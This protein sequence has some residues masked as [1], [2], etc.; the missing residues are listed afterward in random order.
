[1]PFL[2]MF[3]KAEV[4]TLKVRYLFSSGKKNFLRTR[5]TLNFLLVF[6]FENETR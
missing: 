3:L 4:D 6:L 1:M 2:L 5:F